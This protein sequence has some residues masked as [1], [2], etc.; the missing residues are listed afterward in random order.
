LQHIFLDKPFFIKQ[1][2]VENH[3]IGSLAGRPAA[4]R[5]RALRPLALHQRQVQQAQQLLRLPFH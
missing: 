3:S 2:V 4:C 1:L 5:L